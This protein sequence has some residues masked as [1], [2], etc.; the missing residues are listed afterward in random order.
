MGAEV[1]RRTRG[2]A[3]FLLIALLSASSSAAPSAPRP[4]TDQ[5]DEFFYSPSR[6]PPP[7][8]PKDADD[9][10]KLVLQ[11]MLKQHMPGVSIV[12]RDHGTT[13]KLRSY[14]YADLETCAPATDSTLFGIGSISKHFT[15]AGALMLVKSGVVSLDDPI[16]KYLPEGKGVWDGI[17]VRNL[18]TH[19]SGIPDYCGDDRKFPSIALDRAASPETSALVKQIAEAPL[20]FPPGTDW[21]YSNTGFLLLS[22]LIERA[23]GQPFASF[24]RDRVF[25]PA[26]MT[27]TRYYSPIE[28][29][30][31]GA[32]PYWV[33]SIAPYT[34]VPTSDKPLDA[35]DKLSRH[36]VTHGPFVSDQ[37]SHW[38]DM[39]MLTTSGDLAR[40]YE[41][42][43]SD[44][45][46]PEDLRQKLWTDTRLKDGAEVP[47]GFGLQ[48][49]QVGTRLEI[50]HSGSF[51]VGF[52]AMF[53]IIPDTQLGVAVMS[54]YYGPGP[55]VYGLGDKLV[56]NFDPWLAGPGAWKKSADPDPSL[57]AA[58]L[59]RMRGATSDDPIG[60]TENYIRHTNIKA[61]RE[62]FLKGQRGLQFSRCFNVAGTPGGAFGSRVSRQCAWIVTGGLPDEPAGLLAWFT[63]DQK[64]AGSF[65]WN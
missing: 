18:L 3:A 7:A 4:L 64:L 15:A 35:K 1:Q 54:N 57:T 51:R 34:G 30:P 23:S 49:D 10:D 37:F 28:I 22:V 60:T 36:R 21:A 38:G 20:N 55:G 24:M 13:R 42:L 43:E 39:G 48:L 45:L 14:G 19:T 47:Y 27:S 29:I 8:L 31:G 11:A 16:V 58:L 40:W 12:I 46:L 2:I 41:T 5:T 17:L 62:Y 61:L 26:G 52:T 65:L 56:G 6:C 33:D 53:Y 59:A 44:R 9:V 32:T 50:D 63:P 25:A